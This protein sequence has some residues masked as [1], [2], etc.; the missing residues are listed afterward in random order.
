[1]SEN[2]KFYKE[3]NIAPG[4]SVQESHIQFLEKRKK[5]YRQLGIPLL[6]IENKDAIE[7]GA[8]CGE[9]SLP[10]VAGFGDIYKGG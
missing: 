8:S 5:L 6:S 7:F 9:N 3:H 1:M 2:I 4:I 10:L